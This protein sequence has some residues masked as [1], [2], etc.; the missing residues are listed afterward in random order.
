MIYLATAPVGYTLYY[1]YGFG[2]SDTFG[3]LGSCTRGSSGSHFH[4]PKAQRA[5]SIPA[6]IRYLLT[7][8]IIAGYEIHVHFSEIPLYYFSFTG[9]LASVLRRWC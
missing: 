9:T 7:T 1:Y 5:S 8:M 3:V 6:A 4:R 2:D